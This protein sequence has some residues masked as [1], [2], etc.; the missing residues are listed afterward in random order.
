MSINIRTQD[1]LQK[2]STQ[3]LT[4]SISSAEIVAALKYIPANEQIVN[5]SIEELKNNNTIEY[6]EK[7]KYNKPL[8]PLSA[9]GVVKSDGTVTI[10][11]ENTSIVT[12]NA[13]QKW[14]YYGFPATI[15]SGKSYLIIWKGT[16]PTS[17]GVQSNGW[18]ITRA[19]RTITIDGTTYK[20]GIVHPTESVKQY[21]YLHTGFTVGTPSTIELIHFAEYDS[22]ITAESASTDN[23][24]INL[25]EQKSFNIFDTLTELTAPKEWEG[26]K[27]L[28]IGDSL[29]AAG[30]WQTKLKSML[31]MEVTTHAKGGLGMVA[32]I[33]GN[34]SDFPALTSSDVADKDLIIFFAGYNDR[35]SLVGN[36]SDTAAASGTYVSKTKYVIEKIYALLSSASNL[37]CRVILITPHCAGK[38][39]Y[40]PYD[41]YS[42]YPVGSGQTLETVA[43]TIEAVATSYNIPCYNAWKY[44]GINKFTWKV[45]AASSTP[46]TGETVNDQL[47]LNNSKG[48][49]HLGECIAKFVRT[50]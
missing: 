1:G 47:H 25:I 48:Y 38:Y 33:D 6:A 32:C 10:S 45:Y 15:E 13:T 18:H 22:S 16:P 2:F 14:S 34:G 12:L 42:E 21:I 17:F 27:A 24:V 31:G 40:I 29:T 20:Y 7:T 11:A 8:I 3:G 28:V 30:V 44:S 26:K 5:A 46:M 41:G 36:M 9:V 50:I 39:S 49:P 19:A 37:T 35:G 23:D 43:N 4:S